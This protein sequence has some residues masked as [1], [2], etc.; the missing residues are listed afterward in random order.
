LHGIGNYDIL[1]L[2]HLGEWVMSL[3]IIL[4]IVVLLACVVYEMIKLAAILIL[5]L[6]LATA[7]KSTKT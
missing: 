2:V 1:V 4:G 3:K 6:V 5:L 7:W